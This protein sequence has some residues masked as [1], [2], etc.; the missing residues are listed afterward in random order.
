[1]VEHIVVVGHIAAAGDIAVVVVVV[2]P[3]VAPQ[4]RKTPAAAVAAAVVGSIVRVAGHRNHS[5]KS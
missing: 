3:L 2:A 5:H 4:V 1:M